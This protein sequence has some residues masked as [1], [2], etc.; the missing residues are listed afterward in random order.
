[1]D[2]FSK[3]ARIVINEKPYIV[4]RNSSVE[5]MTN[6]GGFN[7]VLRRLFLTEKNESNIVG[8]I[9]FFL[10]ISSAYSWKTN[11]KTLYGFGEMLEFSFANLL[12]HL[13]LR[14]DEI[15][16]AFKLPGQQCII[17]TF[18]DDSDGFKTD[19]INYS[20]KLTDSFFDTAQKIV[21]KNGVNRK[22]VKH[23]ILQILLN[24]Y[25]ENPNTFMKIE[26]LEA[27][28]PLST[29]ELLTYLH[30]LKEE[31]KIDFIASVG[32]PPKIIS[33][34]IKVAG[35]N[36]LENEV[37]PVVNY[38]QAMVKQVFGTNIE[39]TT[40]G[41][42][43]PITVSIDEIKTVFESLQKEIQENLEIQNKKELLNTVKELEVEVVKK[44]N[45]NKIRELLGKVR[46]SAGWVYT[47]IINNP[48][49]A[50]VI[51][52]LLLRAIPK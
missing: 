8:C 43:S 24:E 30:L 42:N 33:V 25:E 18:G 10:G 35:I 14:V 2:Q 40:Y 44:D 13:V 45:P 9:V 20:I 28:I 41:S 17:C 6:D 15:R 32:D 51:T 50:G 7:K 27:S 21:F 23:E 31:D 19:K 52:D 12:P 49:I 34:K 26:N 22:Q 36:H 47:R 29:K 3:V 11:E 37:N 5:G 48:I 38:Q 1:M 16:Q 4:L 46:N 39:N